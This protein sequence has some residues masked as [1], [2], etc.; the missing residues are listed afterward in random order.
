MELFI[1][2]REVYGRTLYY[3]A[4]DQSKLLAKLSGKA[5]FTTET[6]DI[7]KQLGYTLTTKQ[8]EVTL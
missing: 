4:C 5:T 3:P 1:N 7:I 6:I 8:Q 2:P